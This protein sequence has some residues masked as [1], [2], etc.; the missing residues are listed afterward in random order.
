[1]LALDMAIESLRGGGCVP[2][3][4]RRRIAERLSERAAAQGETESKES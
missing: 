3:E 2:H 4:Y 1:M